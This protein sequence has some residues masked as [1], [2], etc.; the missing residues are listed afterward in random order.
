MI[1]QICRT[2]KPL[3]NIYTILFIWLLAITNFYLCIK[4]MKDYAVI[5]GLKT[6][7]V[8]LDALNYYTSDEGYQTLTVLGVD[9]RNAYRLTNYYDFVLPFFLFL[10]L[11]LPNIALDESCHCVI[12][13]FIYMISDYIE[14]LAEKYVLEIYPERNDLMMT[15]ASYTGLIKISFFYISVLIV[16]INLIKWIIKQSKKTKLK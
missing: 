5:A 9:G 8:V 16:I 13:P 3:A 6:T 7:P 1:E 10:S 11:S 15:L 14:N 2:L 12:A 4:P